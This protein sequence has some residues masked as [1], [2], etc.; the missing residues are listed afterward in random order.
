VIHNSCDW[1]FISLLPWATECQG[2]KSNE[3]SSFDDV[4]PCGYLAGKE[5]VTVAAA[6]LF[7]QYFLLK[8]WKPWITLL[9]LLDN[10]YN[11][12]EGPEQNRHDSPGTSLITTCLGNL[13]YSLPLKG[14]KAV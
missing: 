7:S 11:E 14:W 9:P 4:C 2:E 5:E 8:V 6:L 10:E 3:D 12:S 13:C 1:P